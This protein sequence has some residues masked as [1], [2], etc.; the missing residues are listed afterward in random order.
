MAKK[1]TIRTIPQARTPM[2]EQAPE[3]RVKNFD[4][5]AC[6]Y[7][8]E[9]ALVESERCLD[10]ADQPCVRGCPVGIDIVQ[11]VNRLARSF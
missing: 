6:G 2:P 5:V 8:I 1:K 7:R 4:E 11:V 10:C 9:D 3:A